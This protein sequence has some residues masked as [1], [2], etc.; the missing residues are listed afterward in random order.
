MRDR[1]P[2]AR[3]SRSDLD[4]MIALIVTA[5][6]VCLA[7]AVGAAA[8]LTVALKAAWIAV[9][10]VLFLVWVDYVAL[11]GCVRLCREGARP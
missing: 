7:L 3:P 9:G 6:A 10:V 11:R 4:T 5:F 2:T 8:V 1:N